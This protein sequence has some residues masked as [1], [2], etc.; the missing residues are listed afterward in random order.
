MLDLNKMTSFDQPLSNPPIF[1]FTVPTGYRYMI[2]Q[3]L[4]GFAPNSKLQPWYFL[5]HDSV[6]EVT[7]KWPEVPYPKGDLIAFA[8]RQDYDELACFCMAKGK[9]VAIVLI[10]AWTGSG[11]TILA[12]YKSFWDWL[13]AVIDDISSWVED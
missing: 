3:D 12:E 9:T 4:V 8:R 10:H 11:Y 1:S 7:R 13:K 2:A 6:I 5:D